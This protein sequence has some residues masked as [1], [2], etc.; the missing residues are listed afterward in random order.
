MRQKTRKRNYSFSSILFFRKTSVNWAIILWV[1]ISYFDSI[2]CF[3]K[4]SR[5]GRINPLA[6]NLSLFDF[7]PSLLF[8]KEV[9]AQRK[10]NR[11][12]A[13]PNLSNPTL[14]PTL[15]HNFS[16]F[17]AKIY[18][19]PIRQEYSLAESKVA[20]ERKNKNS[21]EG[22]INPRQGSRVHWIIASGRRRRSHLAPPARVMA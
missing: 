22:S 3:L 9:I 17:V 13:P 16:R 19:S 4:N 6:L 5:K 2:D 15:T 11:S 20:S 8:K 1:K 18:Y 21:H 14:L 10:Y 12:L 7:D